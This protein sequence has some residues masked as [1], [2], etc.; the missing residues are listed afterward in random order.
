MYNKGAVAV[1]APFSMGRALLGGRGHG[2]ARRSY[3]CVGARHV[4][5]F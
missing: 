4:V 2:S 3:F 1:T 5:P